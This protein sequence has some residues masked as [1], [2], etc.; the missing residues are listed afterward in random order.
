MNVFKER[1]TSVSFV[2]VP[3]LLPQSNFEPL[4]PC[5]P[6]NSWPLCHLTTSFWNVLFL[7]APF[8]QHFFP[9]TFVK[10]S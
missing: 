2:I 1:K 7:L 9:S 6:V 5:C 8:G 4:S 10:V 3:P